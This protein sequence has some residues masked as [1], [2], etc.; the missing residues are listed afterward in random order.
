[1]NFRQF[2]IKSIG[3]INSIR[4]SANAHKSKKYVKKQVKLGNCY[5]GSDEE[6]RNKVLPY[7]EKYNYKP[8][9]F[10][11]QYFG[12][13]QQS[14]DPGIIPGD[15]FQKEIMP[16]L[17]DL[18]YQ[19]TLENKIYFDQIL[20]DLHKPKMIFK[21]LNGFL[22]D[23]SNNFITKEEMIELIKGYNK[24]IIKPMDGEKGNGVKILNIE[25]N[26]EESIK[27]INS[28]LDNQQFLVQEV[29]KQSPQLSKFNP[30]SV[31]TIRVISL[32]IG[33]RVEILSSIIRVGAPGSCVDNYHK[34]GDTRPIGADGCLKGYLMKP[35]GFS[36]IDRDGSP[37]SK[38]KII[39]YDDIVKTIKFAHPRFPHLRW[40]GWDF[41]ID[42]NYQPTFIELNG[43]AGENQREDG[44]SFAHVTDEFLDEFFANR[45]K[46]RFERNDI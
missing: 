4:L 26:Y 6:Y 22:I 29:I 19:P 36:T 38:E 37:L 43:Y 17:N 42:E 12:N 31:N 24:L 44:P 15:L 8:A 18:G 7:W 34:G 20:H 5:Q 39:G 46:K 33:G 3:K 9:K 16:Y 40:I 27:E 13:Q 14:F 10:W 41:A 11:F 1:M 32:L 23:G 30:S 35:E 2:R 28:R 25:D 45:G 21:Y